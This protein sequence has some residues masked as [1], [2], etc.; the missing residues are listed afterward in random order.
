MVANPKIAESYH[1]ATLSFVHTEFDTAETFADIARSSKDATKTER[2]RKNARKG[3]DT[4]LRFLATIV[5][6][7]DEMPGVQQRLDEVRGKLR[8]LGETF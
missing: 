7:P 6:G 5:V 8:A 4:A 2:N 3:Y 1:R